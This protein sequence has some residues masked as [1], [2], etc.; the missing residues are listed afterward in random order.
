MGALVQPANVATAADAAVM[1]RSVRAWLCER[2]IG[3][4]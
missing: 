2:G 3:E 1:R 4:A